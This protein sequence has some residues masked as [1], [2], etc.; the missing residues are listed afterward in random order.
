MADPLIPGFKPLGGKSRNY[1]NEKTGEILSRRQFDKLRD[2]FYEKKAAENK[3][4]DQLEQLARPAKGRKSVRKVTPAFKKSIV[5]ARAE[6]QAEEIAAE[7]ARKDM[8]AK[9]RMVQRRAA[10]RIHVKKIRDQLLEAGRV[11]ARIPFNTFAEYVDL[12]KQIQKM[13]EKIF[14]YSL[15]ITYIVTEERSEVGQERDVTVFTLMVAK[16]FIDEEEFDEAMRADMQERTYLKFAHFWMHLKF[17]NKFAQAKAT[18]AGI[19]RNFNIR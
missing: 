18:R 11:G 3:A 19:K 5:E 12:W 9:V 14:A 10:K 15:G 8:A 1:V 17:G 4:K 16:D 2:I 7:K 6:K 13:G